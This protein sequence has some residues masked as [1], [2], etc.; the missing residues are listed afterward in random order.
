MLL[1]VLLDQ[2]LLNS[3]YFR[4]EQW[5]QWLTTEYLTFFFYVYSDTLYIGQ[6]LTWE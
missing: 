3:N 6:L 4:S 1:K 2:M 5:P